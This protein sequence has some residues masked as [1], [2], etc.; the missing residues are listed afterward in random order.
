MEKRIGEN[1][2]VYLEKF[3]KEEMYGFFRTFSVVETV[4]I[5]S[6]F[7]KD[8]PVDEKTESVIRELFW[9]ALTLFEGLGFENLNGVERK[10][11]SDMSLD[12]MRGAILYGHYEGYE[13]DGVN[14]FIC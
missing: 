11:T 13:K 2:T 4:N 14:Y 5:F 7:L 8:S 1:G 6:G 12:D 9:K 3:D 10:I